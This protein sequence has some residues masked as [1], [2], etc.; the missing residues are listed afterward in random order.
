VA[1]AVQEDCTSTSVTVTRGG[2][3][4]ARATVDYTSVDGT[5]K[6]KG[7][8]IYATGRLVFEAGET[9]KSFPLLINE[10]SY[11]EG[12]ETATIVL[13][14]PSAGNALAVP[15]TATVQIADDTTE[16]ATN[17]LDN[18]RGFVCQQ[19]HDFLNRQSDQAGEDFWTNEITSCGN[20]ATC[21]DEKRTNVSA[22][23]FLS[24][25]FQ[26]SGYLV[27]RAHKAAF[28]SDKSNP[29]YIVFLRDQR[30]IAEGVVFGSPGAGALLEQ[31]TVRFFEEFVQRPEFLARFPVGTPAA[32]YVD[33]L[34]AN[35]GVT[36]TTAERNAAITAYGS[37]DTAGRGAALRKVADSDSVY[38]QQYNPA[39]VL[40]EY[41]GY[42]RRNPDDPPD[43]TFDG[44]DFWLGKMNQYSLPNED[45]RNDSVALSRVR[46]AEMV[47]AFLVSCEYRERFF[48]SASGNQFAPASDER[49]G[50]GR[51][52][53]HLFRPR[54]RRT[55]SDFLGLNTSSG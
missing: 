46:R 1:Y 45:V 39:F 17:P 18:A 29:R 30:Q 5:A 26:A 13:S 41:Y 25:E 53:D 16:T 44:Y 54:P 11:T 21:I 36:P 6:Q 27:I 19:Y 52:I 24:I 37:G 31:N 33:T 2:V 23:F 47:K 42:L 9:Q 34:F 15:A 43:N 22:A 32:T 38:R 35:A 8:Y 48:G 51:F 49:I 10:D 12:P 40:M 4:T 55:L 28:G 3:T 20:N 14:N 50:A 7:D